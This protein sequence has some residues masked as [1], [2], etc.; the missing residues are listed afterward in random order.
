MRCYAFRS[1]TRRGDCNVTIAI[2]CTYLRRTFDGHL[3]G[4]AK[5][6]PRVREQ[7]RC[8]PRRAEAEA[9]SRRAFLRRLRTSEAP[10]ISPRENMRETPRGRRSQKPRRHGGRPC[11]LTGRIMPR[12]SHRWLSPAGPRGGTAL[13]GSHGCAS[14]TAP[15]WSVGGQK[16]NL[17]PGVIHGGRSAM[18]CPPSTAPHPERESGGVEPHLRQKMLGI[19]AH[20]H[21]SWKPETD[22][23]YFTV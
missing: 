4:M 1:G 15:G 14:A 22:K 20:C 6:V 19:S 8:S 5:V 12:S 9:Q 10:C 23:R 16:P 7:M 13:C 11:M 18:I 2:T 17:K 3:P 21:L